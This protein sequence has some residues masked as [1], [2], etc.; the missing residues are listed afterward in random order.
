MAKL[1]NLS[2]LQGN[3]ANLEL[4]VVYLRCTGLE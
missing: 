3:T 1:N 2:H 4:D